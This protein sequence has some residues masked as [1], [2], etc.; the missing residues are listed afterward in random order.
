MCILQRDAPFGVA[1]AWAVRMCMHDTMQRHK[2]TRPWNELVSELTNELTGSEVC[3]LRKRWHAGHSACL[4]F[5]RTAVCTALREQ[6]VNRRLL[7]RRRQ[8]TDRH[9]INVER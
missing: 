1:A 8:L 4:R 5:K 3:A 7:L 9:D 2:S 6:L